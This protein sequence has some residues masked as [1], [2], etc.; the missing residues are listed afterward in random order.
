MKEK[1]RQFYESGQAWAGVEIGAIPITE[2]L[3]WLRFQVYLDFRTQ[4]HDGPTAMQLTA[5]HTKTSYVT[6]WR[7][8]KYFS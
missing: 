7:A 6:V 3:K 1:R 8:V 5:D 4:G 2:Y